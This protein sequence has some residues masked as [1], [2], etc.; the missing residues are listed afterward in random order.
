MTGGTFVGIYPVHLDRFGV[1]AHMRIVSKAF[2]QLFFHGRSLAM[3]LIE[4][5][6]SIH[7]YVHLNGIAVADAPCAQVVYLANVGHLECCGY[8]FL[9]NLIGQ[10]AFCQFID[11]AF[12][13]CE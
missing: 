5:N 7:A 3:R 1:D 11:A 2:F 6:V 8:D 13:L 10:R 9:L 4:R 12:Q